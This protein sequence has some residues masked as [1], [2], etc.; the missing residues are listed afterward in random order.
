LGEASAGE[1][2]V[3]ESVVHLYHVSRSVGSLSFEAR[4]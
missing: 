4:N 3:L 2:Y 1:G